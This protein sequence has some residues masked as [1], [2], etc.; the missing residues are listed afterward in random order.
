MF[1]IT[2]GEYMVTISDTTSDTYG[3]DCRHARLVETLDVGK[4]ESYKSSSLFLSIARGGASPF[5]VVTQKYSPGPDQGF[6]PGIMLVP[7]THLL[8]IGAGERLLAY[9]LE[10]VERLWEDYTVMGFWG[11][12]RYQDWII[13]SA[14]MELAVWD[15]HGHKQWSF[16][17]EPPWDY[18]L[19]GDTVQLEVMG[20][21]SSFSLQDGPPPPS[22]EAGK[23][24]S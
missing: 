6:Y 22:R 3:H 12:E 7:E 16:P 18:H 20:Q 10:P 21:R 19:E 23:N 8:F 4:W 15:T 17:V 1:R 9:R 11:W 24:S 5:L 14:E 13:M 2:L